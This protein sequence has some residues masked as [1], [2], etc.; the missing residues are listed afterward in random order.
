MYG[1]LKIR[2]VSLFEFNGA[3][4]RIKFLFY[5]ICETKSKKRQH[6]EYFHATKQNPYNFNY[7]LKFCLNM[8][9]C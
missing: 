8:N 6:A 7:Q 5:V 4:I 3:K 2:R 9:V 1:Y